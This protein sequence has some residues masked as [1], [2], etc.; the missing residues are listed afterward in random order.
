MLI[1]FYIVETCGDDVEGAGLHLVSQVV[2]GPAQDG[3]V[4]QLVEGGVD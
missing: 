2:G 4:V 1:I 3:P